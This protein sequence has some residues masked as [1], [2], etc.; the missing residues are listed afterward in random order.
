M[1]N[2]DKVG[3][4]GTWT[5]RIRQVRN[6]L[7]MQRTFHRSLSCL[8]HCVLRS[9]GNSDCLLFVAHS[10]L[11]EL[12]ET[13]ALLVQNV[14]GKRKSTK[15]QYSFNICNFSE[16]LWGVILLLRANLLLQSS[17]LP[18]SNREQSI[19]A[20]QSRLPIKQSC[21]RKNYGYADARTLQR[22]KNGNGCTSMVAQKGHFQAETSSNACALRQLADVGRILQPSAVKNGIE[23]QQVIV[24]CCVIIVEAMSRQ[25][26]NPLAFSSEERHWVAEIEKRRATSSSLRFCTVVSGC[27]SA[28]ASSTQL[29]WFL[30]YKGSD[31]SHS[32]S[33]AHINLR[34]LS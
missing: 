26:W 15:Q 3:M 5:I 1:L 2:G 28:A 27:W 22:C 20:V 12:F 19:I 9:L 16:P 7:S 11:S 31:D 33:V 13:I 34:L 23:W 21:K 32:V 18:L 17:N 25:G 29:K 14:S 24:C 30:E 10:K 6:V 4:N 8:L